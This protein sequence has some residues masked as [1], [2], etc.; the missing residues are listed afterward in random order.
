[1]WMKFIYLLAEGFRALWRA[2]VPAVGSVV[3]IAMTLIIFSTAFVILSN[4][5]KATRRLQSQYRI[6]VFFDPLLEGAE[7]FSVYQRLRSIEGIAS[8]E[9][10]TK[11]DAAAIFKREF[12]EDVVSTVGTNPLP[13]GAVVHVARQYRTARRIDKIAD[14]I[15]RIEGVADVGYRGELVRIMEKYI[16]FA[17]I[18]GITVGLVALLGS[19]FLISNTIKLS[20]YA[21]QDSIEVLHLLG[22]TRRFIR[23]PFL[24]EGV[25]QGIF[26]SAL[27][28]SVMFGLLN[29]VNYIL[30]QFVL[31]RLIRPP[32]MVAGALIMGII[33]GWTGSAR[34]I[35]R[36]I[37]PRFI[38]TK[39]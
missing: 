35:R 37:S 22:A 8:T 5:D 21:K 12:G 27:A 28:I 4:F 19:I 38:R 13:A 25:V 14:D 11:D 6:Q 7:A 15:S 31:Y 33:L 18:G 17:V 30:E 29:M 16:R 10:I 26:G 2:K 34:S 3:T 32:Q 39:Q 36:F 1:M 9:F 20:I 24:V 23:M